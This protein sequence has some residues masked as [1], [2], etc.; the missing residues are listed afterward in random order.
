MCRRVLASEPTNA[1]AA[2]LLGVVALQ[3]TCAEEAVQWLRRAL[4]LRPDFPEALN[5]LGVALEA[6]G[7]LA[8]AEPTPSPTRRG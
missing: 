4:L 1:L 2:Q 6:K 8:E 5:N 7:Q 3:T